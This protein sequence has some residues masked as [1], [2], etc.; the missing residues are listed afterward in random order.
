MDFDKT[1]QFEATLINLLSEDS[2]L[3]TEM[4]VRD[5]EG[6][7]KRAFVDARAAECGPAGRLPVHRC[8]PAPPIVDDDSRCP[9]F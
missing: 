4:W 3:G 8:M 2:E 7:R 9:L 6:S 5:K 1:F